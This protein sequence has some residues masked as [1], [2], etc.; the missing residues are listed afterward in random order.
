MV[1]RGATEI[2][3]TIISLS[4]RLNRLFSSYI[5][6]SSQVKSR[7]RIFS[8]VRP[9]YEGAVSNLDRSIMRNTC[10]FI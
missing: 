3:S 1:F 5:E 9:F 4:G 10:C 8:H 7:G 2:I 6:N